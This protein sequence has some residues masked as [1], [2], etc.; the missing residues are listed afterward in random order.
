MGVC[1][2]RAAV[3]ETMRFAASKPKEEILQAYE[4][5]TKHKLS[6]FGT[7][8]QDRLAAVLHSAG[9]L[10]LQ[11]WAQLLPLQEHAVTPPSVRLDAGP[12][13]D[14]LLERTQA[15][16]VASVVMS[17]ASGRWLNA[18]MAQLA[19]GVLAFFSS[20]VSPLGNVGHTFNCMSSP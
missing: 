4:E 17:V 9:P 8:A 16:R 18:V 10:I 20:A 14:A 13:Y 3:S 19:Q 5:A 15:T 7:L 6:V 12:L 2:W 11:T 1:S